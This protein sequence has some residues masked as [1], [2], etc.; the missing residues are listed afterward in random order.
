MLLLQAHAASVQPFVSLLDDQFA[1]ILG[2]AS[3]VLLWSISP[4]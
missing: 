4:A 3:S 1:G 2:I